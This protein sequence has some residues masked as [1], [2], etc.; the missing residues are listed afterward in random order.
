MVSSN[1]NPTR[2]GQPTAYNNKYVW[3]KHGFLFLDKRL[4]KEVFAPFLPNACEDLTCDQTIVV[5]NN[6]LSKPHFLMPLLQARLQK[7]DT[8]LQKLKGILQELQ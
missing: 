2:F 4:G 1:K 8:M 5:W 7:S 3:N 6:V